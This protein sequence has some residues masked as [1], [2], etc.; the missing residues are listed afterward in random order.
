MFLPFYD[1]TE[2]K[3]FWDDQ[4]RRRARTHFLI[5]QAE[6]RKKGR[7]F[8]P[9]LG[10][11][12]YCQWKSQTSD[13]L[14]VYQPAATD[15]RYTRTDNSAHFFAPPSR[16]VRASEPEFVWESYLGLSL[17]LPSLKSCIDS[18]V[19]MERFGMVSPCY[20]PALVGWGNGWQRVK[21]GKIHT[22]KKKRR[23]VE[24]LCQPCL[25]PPLYPPL[26]YTVQRYVGMFS[27][28]V[29]PRKVSSRIFFGADFAELT[30]GADWIIS[31]CNAHGIITL[32]P[33]QRWRNK[34]VQ[35]SRISNLWKE[36]KE[37]KR[38]KLF[39]LQRLR[40]GC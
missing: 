16:K 35:A 25:F 36:I 14:R 19:Y 26:A 29:S 34:T 2:K 30:R 40:G 31:M 18:H 8:L 24:E 11:L 13:T 37:H 32:F 6:R 7:I 1:G 38:E 20:K 3:P 4:P 17:L 12:T 15:Q 22:V 39:T 23:E 9:I 28:S 21:V 5:M 27:S 33:W 10:L